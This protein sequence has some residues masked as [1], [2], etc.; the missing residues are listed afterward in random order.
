MR[1]SWINQ[2]GRVHINYKKNNLFQLNNFREMTKSLTI[3]Q[4]SSFIKKIR[5]AKKTMN[6]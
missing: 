3:A 1:I 2:I 6:S 5:N 4:K